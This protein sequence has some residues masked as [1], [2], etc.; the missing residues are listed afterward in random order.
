MKWNKTTEPTCDILGQ[1]GGMVV[2]Q[3]EDAGGNNHEGEYEYVAVV[4]PPP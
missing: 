1:N 4:V 2:R 3:L